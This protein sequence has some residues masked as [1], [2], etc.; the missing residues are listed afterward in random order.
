MVVPLVVRAWSDVEIGIEIGIS[1]LEE[2]DVGGANVIEGIIH[3][4]IFT[5]KFKQGVTL[6]VVLEILA[7]TGE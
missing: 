1:Q 6:Y 5:E 4:A 7:D 2:L 3:T